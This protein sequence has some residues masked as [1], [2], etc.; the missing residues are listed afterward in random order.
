MTRLSS[1]YVS[2]IPK[3]IAAYDYELNRKTG[4]T[5]KQV[6][7]RA[8]DIPEN[9]LKNALFH[10]RVSV[11]PITAGKGL[12]PGFGKAVQSILR[13]IGFSCLL[14]SK[15]D[16]SGIA[17]SVERKASLI[18]LADD[19]RFVAIHLAHQIV[20]DNSA[21]TA[22]GYVAAL[23]A[24]VGG[25]DGQK[26]LLIGA[27]R[28]GQHACRALQ[29]FGAKVGIF[30]INEEKAESLAKQTGEFAEKDLFTALS[31][32]SIL[33]DASPA[34]EIIQAQHIKDDTSIAAC[35]IPAGLTPE[36]FALVQ[37]RLIHDPLQIGVATMAVMAVCGPTHRWKDGG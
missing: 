27:G 14:T 35:G 23:D 5:L 6:A 24:L 8:A 20:I 37:E 7:C 25:L 3:D 13:H 2:N 31:E 26:V 19:E 12:I 34:P 15:T 1:N 33:F 36:A 17:E 11:V 22:R 4:L 16:V 9:E 29:K 32:Y 10:T 21:A 28:V 30:D 18:F